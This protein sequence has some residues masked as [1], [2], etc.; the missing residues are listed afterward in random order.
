MSLDQD[1]QFDLDGY[2]F[3]TDADV[4]LVEWGPGEEDIRTQDAVLDADDA[5]VFGR[6]RRTPGVLSFDLEIRERAPDDALAV[7]GP[8]RA[9]WD[10]PRTEPRAVSTLRYRLAGRTRRVYGRPR[11]FTPVMS[12]LVLGRVPVV[13][14]FALSD[15]NHYSDAEHSVS[16]DLT[17]ST[18]PL[19]VS[20][21]IRSPFAATFGAWTAPQ[22]TAVVSG[23]RSTWP[24]IEFH[25]GTNP[26]CEVAGWRCRVLASL[27]WDE[28]VIVDTRPWV[29]SS[30]LNGSYAPLDRGSRLAEMALPPGNWPVRYGNDSSAG[31]PS[32][33]VRWRDAFSSL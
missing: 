12:D 15:I 17:G 24:I 1:W 18:N 19:G 11:R 26:W 16:S 20:S 22:R 10:G 5:R 23:D 4:H 33:V 21:P 7:L 27:N 2:V 25:G 6:D 31:A 28:T 13:A 29:R 9:S 30:T 32:V 14:D 3:G 8:L